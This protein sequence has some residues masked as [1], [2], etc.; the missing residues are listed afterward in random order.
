MLSCGLHA[1]LPHIGALILLLLSR[2]DAYDIIEIEVGKIPDASLTHFIIHIGGLKF[3]CIYSAF[4][5]SYS[6]EPL[7]C[8]RK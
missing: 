4:I 8:S 5:A 2:S 3:I 1:R 6:L 7:H